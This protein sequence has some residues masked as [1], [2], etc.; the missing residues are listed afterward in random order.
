MAF[1]EA[2]SSASSTPGYAGFVG[3]VLLLFA[4]L[5]VMW[6]GLDPS[7]DLRSW[8]TLSFELAFGLAIAMGFGFRLARRA[9]VQSEISGVMLGV[10]GGMA[11]LG[12]QLVLLTADYLLSTAQGVWLSMLAPVAETMFVVAIFEVFRFHFPEISW[13]QI[14]IPTDLCFAVFHYFAYGMRPD[15]ILVEIIL[16]IGN[17]VFVYLYHLT[18]NATVPMVAHFIVN[19]APNS[20]AIGQFLMDWGL[21]FMVLFFVFLIFY[22]Y[23]GGRNR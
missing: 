16:A 21:L 2:A 15:F 10:L 5:S 1:S 17:T 20:Q 12:M 14:A 9:T 6:A 7:T 4:F 18:H 3:A 13:I 23:F 19:V 11:V 8:F 22:L